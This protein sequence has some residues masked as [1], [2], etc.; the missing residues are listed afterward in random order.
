MLFDGGQTKRYRLIPWRVQ[1]LADFQMTDE[2]WESL[3]VPIN[4]AFFFHSSSAAKVVAIYPSPA[5]GI[6]S[7]LTLAAWLDLERANPVLRELMPDVEALLV[8]RMGAA[9][10][11]YRVPI[12]EC[13]RLVGLI[14]GHWRGLSGGTEVWQ[15]CERFFHELNEKVGPARAANDA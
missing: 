2:Q 10:E 15:E 12:D 8:N 9:R 3:H 11:H 14:R 7:L 6:E 1:S 4:L 5:G 13:Y